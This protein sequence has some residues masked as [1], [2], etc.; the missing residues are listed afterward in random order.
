MIAFAFG[1]S[2]LLAG[3]ATVILV[4]QTGLVSTT[5]GST[6]VL[7]AF[8]ASII[9]GLGSL[10][11]AV[12]GGYALGALTVALQVTLPESL[13]AYRDAF[14]FLAL[15]IILLARPQGFLGPRAPR[16]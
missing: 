15:V 16:V 11:G 4:A 7:A 2:G 1:V 5:M 8:V 14:V 9:G 6:P 13:R 10:A 3:V 12:L